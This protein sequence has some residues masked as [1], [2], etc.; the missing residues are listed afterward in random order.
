MRKEESG[1]NLSAA[2]ITESVFHN[3]KAGD[4]AGKGELEIAFGTSNIMAVS[5]K[6]IKTGE[7][8]RTTE[9]IQANHDMKYK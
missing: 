9:S 5:E 2:V 8:V 4:T 6:I 7:V 3:V 1:A